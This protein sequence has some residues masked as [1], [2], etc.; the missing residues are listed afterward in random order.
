MPKSISFSSSDP[1]PYV[2]FAVSL[3]SKSDFEAKTPVPGQIVF[4]EEENLIYFD[5]EYYGITSQ[6][7]ATLTDVAARITVLEGEVGHQGSA[8]AQLTGAYTNLA[9]AVLAIKNNQGEWGTQGVAGMTVT[10]AINDLQSQINGMTTG[11]SSVNTKTGTVVLDGTDLLVGGSGSS[12]TDSVA[13]AIENRVVISS[14][15]TTAKPNSGIQGASLTNTAAI[16]TAISISPFYKT[17]LL[18]T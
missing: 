11:V 16:A 3:L 13:T 18:I 2:S 12:A 7:A 5:G 1:K 17:I 8:L 6:Q 14:T 15:D 4:L 10:E 9:N